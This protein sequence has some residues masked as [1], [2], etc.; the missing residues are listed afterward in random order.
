MKWL[1]D[2]RRFLSKGVLDVSH[3][4]KMKMF[5]C[6]DDESEAYFIFMLMI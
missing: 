1:R 4:Q 6:V 2:F 3:Y 5:F